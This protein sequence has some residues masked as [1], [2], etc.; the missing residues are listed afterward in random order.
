MK[1][2]ELKLSTST[3]TARGSRTL[4]QQDD[5]V[6]PDEVTEVNLNRLHL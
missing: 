5:R 6:D 4:V 3:L 1:V 2:V